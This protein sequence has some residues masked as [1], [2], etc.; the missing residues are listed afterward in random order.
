LHF[1][2]RHDPLEKAVADES[3]KR[4]A[5]EFFMG[6]HIRCLS[7]ITYI[8]KIVDLTRINSK[9]KIANKEWLILSLLSG[10]R[11]QDSRDGQ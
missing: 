1:E 9:E 5:K 8:S 3:P 2:V 6:R 7:Q 11:E 10:R 4:R